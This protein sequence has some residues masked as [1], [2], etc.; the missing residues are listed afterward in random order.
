MKLLNKWKKRE[1]DNGG[2]ALAKRETRGRDTLSRFRNEFDSTFDRVWRDFDRDP[3]LAL[4]NL[5]ATFGGLTDWP[6]IDLAEDD[7]AVT[8]RVDVPGLDPKD[9]DVEVSGNMLSIRGRRD[10][11]WEDKAHGVYRRER[12]SGSFARNITLPSYVDAEKID[13]RY[14]RGSLSITI[15]KIGDKARKRVEVK[16]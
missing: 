10:D 14:D 11:E 7:K 9:V 15:P 5:P 2:G 4:S 16:A 6:A 3:W 12:R 13:A 1:H 8:V